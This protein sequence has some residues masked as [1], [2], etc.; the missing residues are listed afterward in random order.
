MRDFLS[1]LNKVVTEL[2][3]QNMLVFTLKTISFNGFKTL[4]T[5]YHLLAVKNFQKHASHKPNRALNSLF[6][7]FTLIAHEIRQHFDFLV[8][9]ALTRF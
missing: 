6:L 8:K 4:M 9:S 2:S 7:V 5:I 3:L 1:H